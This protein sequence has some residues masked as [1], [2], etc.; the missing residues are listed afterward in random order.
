MRIFKWENDAF[1]KYNLFMECN[2]EEVKNISFIFPE[3]NILSVSLEGLYF[4]LLDT[5]SK[6]ITPLNCLAYAFGGQY[7]EESPIKDQLF[8]LNIDLNEYKF[9]KYTKYDR[10]FYENII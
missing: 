5:G 9:I 7:G 3:E 4:Y 8:N 6:I 2:K 1:G 10:A